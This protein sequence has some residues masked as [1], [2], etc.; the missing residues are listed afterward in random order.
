MNDSWAKPLETVAVVIGIS[1]YRQEELFPLPAAEAD[2]VNFARALR[3]WGI[4]EEHILLFLNQ[5]VNEEKLNA[6]FELL[7]KKKEKYKLIFY[8][9]GHGYRIFG[10]APKSYLIFYESQLKPD[11]CVNAFDLDCFFEK[12]AKMH[13]VES[14]VFIDAC[15][16]RINHFVHPKLEEELRGEPC[17][18]KN[19][20]CLLASGIEAS[21]ENVEEYYGYFTRALLRSLSQL[22]FQNGSPTQFLCEIQ[23]EMELENLP[24]PEMINFG[25]QKIALTSDRGP[26]MDDQGRVYRASFLA[27]IQDVFIQSRCRVL[28]LF[29]DEGIGKTTV[30][31]LLTSAKMA[32]VC[33]MLPL[34]PDE[35]FDPISFLEAEIFE[36]FGCGLEECDRKYPYAFIL[37]DQIERLTREQFQSLFEKMCQC[38]HLRFLC[39]S[40][41]PFYDLMDENVEE[42]VFHL[43]AQPF[44]PQ[45]G[46]LL[47]QKMRPDALAEEVDLMYLISCGNPLKMKKLA[48]LESDFKQIEVE[49]VK[50][51]M[52]AVYACGIYYERELFE[53]VFQLKQGLLEFLERV[54]VFVPWAQGYIPHPIVN[55]FAEPEGLKA[56]AQRI[57]TY[58]C[59]QAESLPKNHE[60]AKSLILTVKCCGYQKQAEK[61]LKKALYCLEV[62]QKNLSYFVDGAEIFLSLPYRTKMHEYLAKTLK[63]LGQTQLSEQLLAAKKSNFEWMAGLTS[64]VM[65][66]MAL[67]FLAFWSPQPPSFTH[68]HIKQTHP[69]FVGRENY[70]NLI[71]EQLVRERTP[72]IVPV[73]VLWGEGGIGKSEIAIAAANELLK[74]FNVVHWINAATEES[75]LS[76]YQQLATQLKIPLAEQE[77]VGV[78]ISK[79]HDFLENHPELTWL[80]IYDNAEKESELPERGNGAILVTTRDQNVWH[81]YPHY[82]VTS[83]FENEALALF[84]K[85]TQREGAEGRLALIKELDSH[86]LSLNLVAHY[87]AE[88][89]WMSEESYV[90]LLSMNK[91]GFL[92]VMPMDHRYA[93][94]LLNSWKMTAKRMHE[95]FPKALQWLHFSSYLYP[96]QIPL[97][98]IEDWLLQSSKSP[99]DAYSLKIEV[100]E[101]LRLVV[102]QALMRFDKTSKNLSV[103]RLK[104]EIFKYDE[105]FEAQTQEQVLKFLVHA[106]EKFEFTDEMERSVEMWPKLR[107]W[108]MH[109]AWFLEKY[110]NAASKTELALL[111]G[112]LGSW[113]TIKCEYKQAEA[114]I[115]EALKIRLELFGKEDLRTV[116]AMNNKGWVLWKTNELERAKV[117]YQEALTL[118][119]KIA[120]DDCIYVHSIRNNLSLV[121]KDLHEYE[122]M[123][124]IN[125]KNIEL[126]RRIYGPTH[127][128][129]ASSM[130]NLAFAHL[131]LQNYDLA[132]MYFEKALECFSKEF[133]EDHP[134]VAITMHNLGRTLLKKGDYQRAGELFVRTIQMYDKYYGKGHPYSALC[135]H[136]IGQLLEKLGKEQEAFVALKS[137][138]SDLRK[139]YKKDHPFMVALL[140]DLSRVSKMLEDEVMLEEIEHFTFPNSP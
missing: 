135:L 119:E 22:R 61:A 27:E 26:W 130:H 94:G 36:R 42:L 55:S 137:A 30:C 112:L 104:Q 17:S 18:N 76:S 109:A 122:S 86:P 44:S 28:F 132:Q 10:K 138:F 63:K 126:R 48:R 16:L 111:N 87:M 73:V 113:K 92:D 34:E 45:E 56:D 140:T 31:R 82:E 133:S 11:A 5:D 58:W 127:F 110:G 23:N 65:A 131:N 8:F 64:L 125:E 53:T 57:L 43:P 25:N 21:F 103:H 19:L 35:L 105:H 90:N 118:L 13:P 69:D 83:F 47:I 77:T 128:Y 1:F 74:H 54:E 52:G 7:S 114:Y 139:V 3:N 80:L 32:T 14:Y 39:A 29:G 75:Y 85:I 107:A 95:K 37:L 106:L 93:N 99:L 124:L 60:I 91:V 24:P 108:E 67:L 62:N 117:I 134:Y 72:D 121:Y 78:L 68:V 66:G 38:V 88:T 120:D 102:N 123:K 98:W 49:E 12:I 70:L 6:V 71:E 100:N 20:F 81:S 79:V 101:I 33:L 41:V 115:D 97:A 89:P 51:A 2:A 59:E 116:V 46:K 84:K 136:N 15:H 4:P 50:K 9:C 40:R 96:D 129:T